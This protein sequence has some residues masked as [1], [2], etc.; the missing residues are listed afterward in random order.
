MILEF[1]QMVIMYLELSV[2]KMRFQ[3]IEKADCAW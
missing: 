2:S 3:A 1:Q